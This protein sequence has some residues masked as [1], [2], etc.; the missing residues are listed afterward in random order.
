M[1]MPPLN[2][3]KGAKQSK[4]SPYC[5]EDRHNRYKDDKAAAAVRVCRTVDSTN[6]NNNLFLSKVIYI[7]DFSTK[8]LPFEIHTLFN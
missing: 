8:E 4:L 3:R 2:N 1:F 5:G 6:Y 7:S